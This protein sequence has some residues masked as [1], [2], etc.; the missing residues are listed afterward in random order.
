[1]ETFNLPTNTKVN[2]VVP[3]NTF[4]SYTNTNKKNLC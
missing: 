3:K 4:D 1:M 2:R